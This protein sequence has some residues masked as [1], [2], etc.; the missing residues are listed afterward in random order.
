MK[1]ILIAICEAICFKIFFI[2]ASL[3]AHCFQH[4]G[5]EEAI[6]AFEIL[7]KLGRFNLSDSNEKE[8][9]NGLIDK[10]FIH[11]DWRFESNNYDAD[12][13]IAV[14]REAVEFNNKIK[15]VCLPEF[16]YGRVEG[17]GTVVGWGKSENS[18][19]S[20]EQHDQLPSKVVIPAINGTHCYTTY[21][22]LAAHSSNRIFCGGYE[23]RETSPCMGDSGGGFYQQS[24]L[25][26]SWYIKG[27]VSGSLANVK[28]GCDINKFSLYTHVARFIDWIQTVTKETNEN[29]LR[30]IDFDCSLS[31]ERFGT[32]TNQIDQKLIFYFTN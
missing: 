5:E 14:L 10:V 20:S 11:P 29:S 31:D 8:T 24:Q 1:S 25:S 15:P 30:F 26:R 27:I 4:K 9:V 6:P 19:R 17:N 32:K 2:F 7:C 13:A 3:A 22:K 16:S 23:S 21:P 12:I 18:S 28:Y